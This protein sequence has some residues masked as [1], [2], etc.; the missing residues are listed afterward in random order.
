VIRWA[1]CP[2]WRGNA[3]V[4]GVEVVSRP[5][6][7]VVCLDAQSR[8]LLLR[9]RDPWDGSILWEPPGGGIEPGETPFQAAIRELQEETGL[10]PAAVIDRPV[11]VHRDVVW[12]GRRVVGPE[13]FFLARYPGDSPELDLSGLME[14]ERH[15]LAGHAWLDLTSLST[16]DGQAGEVDGR[17]EPPELAAAIQRLTSA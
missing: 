17:L 12:N 4:P 15:N 16:M 3:T 1:G 8:V 13:S 10:D 6:V 2:P 7:R 5:A 9:W 14:D 11:T